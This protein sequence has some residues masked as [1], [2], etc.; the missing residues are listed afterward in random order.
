MRQKSLIDRFPQYQDRFRSDL[1]ADLYRNEKSAI[2]GHLLALGMVIG[3]KHDSLPGMQAAIWAAAVTASVIFRALCFRRFRKRTS[4]DASDLHRHTIAISACAMAWSLGFLSV[5]PT[6]NAGDSAFFMMVFAGITSSAVIT[7]SG[8]LKSYAMFSSLV[9]GPP[10]IGMFFAPQPDYGIATMAAVFFLFCGVGVKKANLVHHSALIRR[11]QNSDIMK[12][13][14]AAKK[15]LQVAV[16]KAE[17]AN[18]AKQE[19]LANVSHEIRTPMNGILG[20]TDLVLESELTEDQQTCLQTARRC[21]LSLLHL[22]DELLD[23][24]KIE[25]GKMDMEMVPYELDAVMKDTVEVHRL[26]GRAKAEILLDID[27]A[28]PEQLL[29]DPNRIRQVVNNLLGNAVKFTPKGYIRVSARVLP[30]DEGR[31][32]LQ[33][34][35]AD[36]GVGIPEDRLESIFESFTQADGS[37]TRN[38]GGTGL[39]LTITRSLIELMG[40]NMSVESEVGVG[41]TFHATIPLNDATRKSLAAPCAALVLGENAAAL[42]Q[43][44]PLA[45][46]NALAAEIDGELWNVARECYRDVN[47]HRFLFLDR[48]SFEQHTELIS[49]F[50]RHFRCTAV[51]TDAVPDEGTPAPYAILDGDLDSAF[52]D[53]LISRCKEEEELEMEP[54]PKEVG[55]LRILV[56]EDHPTNALIVRRMLEGMGHHVTHSPDGKQAVQAFQEGGADLILMD[57]QMPVMGGHDACRAIRALPDGKEIPILAL[58]AHATSEER[59]RSREAG[60]DDHLTKPFTRDQLTEALQV[61]GSRT[62]TSSEA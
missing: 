62:H 60:M 58:T 33:I 49:A 37:T 14:G 54:E 20:M 22:I 55:P 11:Y 46:A 30:D 50:L 47:A 16:T 53:N 3:F 51:F 10:V 28:I 38:Y 36:E 45:G 42:V 8:R 59:E 23:F 56:A 40:G 48:A 5:L 61:W 39:G 12:D 24:S 35:V 6:L 34:S 15:D 32:Q 25:A 4:Y 57:L 9:L 7:L 31:H 41:S 27:K 26:S 44:L 13:L 1:V 19:F 2:V 21:G 18:Q 17:S 52:L 43:A 29:G